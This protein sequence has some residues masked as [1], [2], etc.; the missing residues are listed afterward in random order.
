M[1]QI[2]LLP[3]HSKATVSRFTLLFSASTVDSTPYTYPNLSVVTSSPNLLLNVRPKSSSQGLE[4]NLPRRRRASLHAPSRPCL[5]DDCRALGCGA[6]MPWVQEL[7]SSSDDMFV[8]QFLFLRFAH[9][10]LRSLEF[11]IVHQL[12]T[13]V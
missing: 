12:S 2:A 7:C 6:D 8:R 5:L 11:H 9:S 13:L 10:H 1:I 4:S 3:Y